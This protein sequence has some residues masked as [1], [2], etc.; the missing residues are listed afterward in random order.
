MRSTAQN[1]ILPR[2]LVLAVPLTYCCKVDQ[3]DFQLERLFLHG[4]A[5]SFGIATEYGLGD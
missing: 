5:S 1:S 2:E 3:G 4:P